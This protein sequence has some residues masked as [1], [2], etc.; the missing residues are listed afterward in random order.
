MRIFII[1]CSLILLLLPSPLL[2]AQD[3][4][5]QMNSTEQGLADSSWPKKPGTQLS[6]L[7]G[8]MKDL[9][10][11]AP[12]DY[13][14]GKEFATTRLFEDRKESSMASVPIWSKSTSSLQG[15]ESAWTTRNPSSL[16]RVGNTR[17]DQ[18][19]S[20]VEGRNVRGEKELARVDAPDW[21][22]RSSPTFQAKDGSLQMYS[23][24]LIR[25]REKVAR[26]DPTS[27]RDL[28]EGKREMFSPNEVKKILEGR[29]TP[30]APLEHAQVQA[31]VKAE[32]PM[33]S[34]PS[35]E[36]N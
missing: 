4:A 36:G 17:Y 22:S 8:K 31:P 33:A 1:I 7:S 14:K 5:S 28:G 20:S 2:Q 21:S 24:R 34:L 35:T 25:V 6:P 9:N 12:R 19:S 15:K 23:G 27:G 11:I 32:S 26:D 29:H 13:G 18:S 30:I 10:Q 16:D 3:S